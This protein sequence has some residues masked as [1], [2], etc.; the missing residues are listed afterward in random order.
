MEREL[1]LGQCY[2]ALD[3][4]RLHLYSR[5]AVLKDRCVNVRHQGPNTKSR[6]LLNGVSTRIVAAADKYTAAYS[7]LDAL[8]P[9]PAAK[10]RTEL[11]VLREEDIRGISEPLLPEHPDP[12]RA[13]AI[14]ARTLLSGGAFLEGSHMP[15]WIWRGAPTGP[16]EASGYSECLSFLSSF[17]WSIWS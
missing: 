10:W 11:L 8:D 6:A 15:S 3:T 4:L 9:D 14:L 2:D 5:S 1:R 16:G 17:I 13:N 12:E 7:A